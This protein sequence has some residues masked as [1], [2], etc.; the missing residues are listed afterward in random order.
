MTSLEGRATKI[1]LRMFT[2]VSYDEIIQIL[3][4]I[5]K[6]LDV[7]TKYFKFM[8]TFADCTESLISCSS[9]QFTL[10]NMMKNRINPDLN[11][12]LPIIGRDAKK[13]NNNKF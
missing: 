4:K 13:S 1:F 9:R 7:L 11:Q 8:R 10:I 2:F 6:K 5:K 3:H 12:C